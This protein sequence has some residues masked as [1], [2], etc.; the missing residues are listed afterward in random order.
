MKFNFSTL[1]EER[2]YLA[3]RPLLSQSAS[4]NYAL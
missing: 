4:Q 2:N 1:N 3:N